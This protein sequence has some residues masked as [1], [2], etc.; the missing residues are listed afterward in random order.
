[1]LG[2]CLAP[3]GNDIAEAQYLQDIAAEWG[4]NMARANLSHT[5]LGFSLQQILMPKLAYLLMATNFTE[6]PY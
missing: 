1:M 6:E 5:E 2:V 3:N 4:R